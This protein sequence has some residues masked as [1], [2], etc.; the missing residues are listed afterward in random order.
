MSRRRG[1]KMKKRPISSITAKAARSIAAA[2][3]EGGMTRRRLHDITGVDLGAISR[4]STGRHYN[5]KLSTIADLLYAAG[6][7][8]KLEPIAPYIDKYRNERRY[9]PAPLP[10]REAK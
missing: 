3:R 4:I 5:A 8:L 2:I 10:P 1:V 7:E 9:R 6:F